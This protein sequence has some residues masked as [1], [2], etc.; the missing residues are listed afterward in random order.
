MKHSQLFRRLRWVWQRPTALLLTASLVAPMI[1]GCGG[2][3]NQASAPPLDATRGEAPMSPN[4]S[5]QS[6]ANSNQGMSKTKKTMIALAGAA[7]LYYLYK[8]NRDSHNQ[9]LPQG[10]QY[11]QSKNGRI[12]YRD[13]KTKQ[14]IWVTPPTQ[15][16]PLMVPQDEIQGLNLQQFRGYNNQDTGRTDFRGLIPMG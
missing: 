4:G 7:A 6:N 3:S 13:P 16:N 1:A 10:V 8:K 14:A 15:Q 9:P 2:S 12:Y 11:Y 5:M